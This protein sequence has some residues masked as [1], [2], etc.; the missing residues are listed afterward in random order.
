MSLAEGTDILLTHFNHTASYPAVL[1]NH[2][3][4]ARNNS[5]YIMRREI[6]Q[7]VT[8]LNIMLFLIMAG[9]QTILADF[10]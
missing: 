6:F 1:G 8:I 4:S 7:A 10:P 9:I 3:K 5:S 2:V